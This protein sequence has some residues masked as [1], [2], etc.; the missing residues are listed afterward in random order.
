MYTSSRV[1]RTTA[2]HGITCALALFCLVVFAQTS[3]AGTQNNTYVVTWTT[4]NVNSDCVATGGFGGWSGSKPTTGSI[5]F[6]PI[7]PVGTYTFSMTCTGAAGSN[8]AGVPITANAPLSIAP[9]SVRTA[10]TPRGASNP[11]YT[12]PTLDFRSSRSWVNHTTGQRTFTLTW[13]YT[14]TRGTC[15]AGGSWSGTKEASSSA[16][17]SNSNYDI[18]TT[19]LETYTI[20]CS[21]PGK[22]RLNASIPITMY[23]PPCRTLG[24]CFIN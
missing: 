23:G 3:H 8:Y 18:G 24:G 6:N 12:E 16:T 20:S 22:P 14:D 5:T 2:R 19:Y 10:I 7:N 11:L 4:S 1:V 13:N 17:F 15:T 9:A 21:A